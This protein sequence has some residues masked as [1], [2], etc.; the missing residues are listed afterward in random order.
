MKKFIA[1]LL[2]ALLLAPVAFAAS[3]ATPTI[4]SK[5]CYEDS[6]G[7]SY[8]RVL[9]TLAFDSTYG[10]NSTT[11]RCGAS[12]LSYQIGLSSIKRMAIEPANASNV[13]ASGGFVQ[14]SYTATGTAGNGL[15]GAVRAMV[16]TVGGAAVGSMGPLVSAASYDF[17]ALTSVPFEAVGPVL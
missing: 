10:C 16:A 15:T 5:Q 6:Q 11:Q 3:T 12:F 1:F 8:C 4:V 13:G 7:V 17:S 9:G 2:V 14:W